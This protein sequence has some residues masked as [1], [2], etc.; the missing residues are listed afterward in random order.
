MKISGQIVDVRNRKIFS[1]SLVIKEGRIVEIIPEIDAPKVY[2]MPGFIDAHIHIESSML[3]PTAF[4]EAAIRFGTVGTISDPHE[5]ANVCGV[6]GVHYMIEDAK[7]AAVKIH[8]G[9][10]SCVPATH[11]ETAGAA[12]SAADVAGLLA[13]PSIYYLS[14][15][16]NYPGVLAGD[17]ALLE[18]IATATRLGKPV[19]GHA[20][21][22]VGPDA[23]R[24]IQ[25]GIHTDHE[26]FTY[27]E[28][29]FKLDHGMKV[30]I[31]EG[32]AAKN[33][34]A[35]HPLISDYS[36]RLMFCS[37]DK[38]PD[39]L[40]LGHIDQLVVR[41]LNQGY[42]LMDV[43][44]MAC[45]N[46]VDHYGMNVGTLRVGDTADFIV[47]KD[48][49]H[50]E[51]LEVYIDGRQAY[52]MGQTI[53]SDS[54]HPKIINHFN[55]TRANF[56]ELSISAKENPMPIIKAI[57]GALITESIM[58]SLP[59]RN[60]HFESDLEKDY[61]KICVVNRYQE[62]PISKGFIHGFGLKSG[63]IASSVAHDSHN[64][65]AVGVDDAAI[66]AVIS[67]LLESKGGLA[68]HLNGRTHG[69]ALPI[70]G[71]MSDQ[72]AEIVAHEYQNL[73][74]MAKE[75]GCGLRAPFMTLSFMALL[76]IPKLKISDRGL[77]DTDQWGMLEAYI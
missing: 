74:R 2:L 42:E 69:L 45:I 7:N 50:F 73:D 48:L 38:H 27:E 75:M 66:E 21:G 63:A 25:A 24:Y 26:C 29:R 9:A 30:L 10:P 4:S 15:V 58:D 54:Y 17:P 59:V 70:A 20:P 72:S 11:F 43:L 55:V 47:V 37:D 60:G 40:I 64:I 5:I 22:L 1:G 3:T 8:F 6:E 41:A 46:P 53:T 67:T 14:E 19:D 23:V 31:R 51:V 57:D 44:T 12:L 76:V 65:I 34:E 68:V 62:A 33:F 77:F 52:K 56:D 36:D 13:H 16:M 32:S 35:L 71:L 39:D 18:M 49:Y 61:L 28:A